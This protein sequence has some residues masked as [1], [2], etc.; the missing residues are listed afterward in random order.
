MTVNAFARIGQ[1]MFFHVCFAAKN[2]N[3]TRESNKSKEYKLFLVGN[4]YQI[5][6]NIVNKQRS[7][8]ISLLLR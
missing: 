3:N 2:P 4:N 8:H 5:N 7:E 1:L 6:S